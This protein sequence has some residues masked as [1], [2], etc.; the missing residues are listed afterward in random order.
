MLAQA[1]AWHPSGLVLATA[2]TDS[3]LRLFNAAVPGG[4]MFTVLAA[5]LAPEA[6]A[7]YCHTTHH[8]CYLRL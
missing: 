4:Q 1:V 6:A 8:A 7:L 5:L 2:S 3:K